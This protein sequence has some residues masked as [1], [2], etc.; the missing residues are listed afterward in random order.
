MHLFLLTTIALLST[1]AFVIVILPSALA[2]IT[3][4]KPKL[5]ENAS[6]YSFPFQKL[7]FLQRHTA[8]SPKSLTGI[9]CTWN[10]LFQLFTHRN[11]HHPLHSYGQ[12]GGTAF[13]C[14]GKQSWAVSSKANKLWPP[15]SHLGP[16]LSP[17]THPC[18]AASQPQ[19]S[20]GQETAP[21][22]WVLQAGCWNRVTPCSNLEL[23][24]FH[25]LI[26]IEL[27]RN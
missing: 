14:P 24:L 22:G 8:F 15:D 5:L 25:L 16:F 7:P 27:I 4:Q 13:P 1:S 11:T 10:S 21:A 2:I 20:T 12:E 9:H 19:R 3:P 17:T 6:S 18:C 23:F 26:F